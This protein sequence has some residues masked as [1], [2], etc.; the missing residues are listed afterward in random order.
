[1]STPS[2]V[3]ERTPLSH[4]YDDAPRVPSNRRTVMVSL[5][6]C[7]FE[8]QTDSGVFARSRLDPGTKILLQEAPALPE[9]GTFVDLGSGAGPIALTMAIRRPR[10]TVW[11]ID[12]NERARHLTS[13]NAQRLHLDGIRVCSPDEVSSEQTFDVIWSNPPI[14]VGK[15]VL[16]DMLETWL[17]R[18]APTGSAVLVVHKNLGSDSLSTW[19]KGKGWLVKRLVSRQGYRVLLVTHAL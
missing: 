8:Y 14:K 15:K 19:L 11:A 1:M 2:D 3:P 17:L 6:D 9:T 5:P 16:H 10:A 13:E 4:Y 12:V 7:S 18:L